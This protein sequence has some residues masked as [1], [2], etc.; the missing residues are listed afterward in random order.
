MF[1]F[2]DFFFHRNAT[3]YSLVFTYL[4]A[5]CVYIVF[6]ATTFHEVIKQRFDYDADV[7]LY[8]AITVL[9]CIVMGEIRKL[10]YLVPFSAM[11]NICI[12]IT[13]GITLYYMLTGPLE[14]KERPLFSSW[15]QLP[16]FFR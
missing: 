15:E 11:A 13:F 14:I 10:K 7:R 4:A 12:V 6:I 3:D 16:L 5:N 8:I 2:Y 1:L 9:P